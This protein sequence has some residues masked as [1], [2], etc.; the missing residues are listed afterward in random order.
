MFAQE[1]VEQHGRPPVIAVDTYMWYFETVSAAKNNYTLAFFNRLNIFKKLGIDLIMVFDG[2]LKI[3][4]QRWGDKTLPGSIAT[5]AVENASYS[6]TSMFGLNGEGSTHRGTTKQS[7][8]EIIKELCKISGLTIVQAPAEGEAEC[9][10]LVKDGVADFVFSGD[11]DVLVFG[12]RN[13]IKYPNKNT[14]VVSWKNDILNTDKPSKNT[15]QGAN[16]LSHSVSDLPSDQMLM[17]VD[18]K[19]LPSSSATDRYICVIRIPEN[20]IF[21]QK[22]SFVFFA[23]LK[24]GDYHNGQNAVGRNYAYEL[25]FPASRYATNFLNIYRETLGPF[26]KLDF[27]SKDSVLN[28]SQIVSIEFI[29]DKMRDELKNNTSKYFSKKFPQ[30]ECAQAFKNFPTDQVILEYLSPL[31][32]SRNHISREQIIGGKQNIYLQKI[33]DYSTEFFQWKQPSHFIN[34]IL[35][36]LLPM[37]K[38]SNK[39][40]MDIVKKVDNSRASAFLDKGSVICGKPS[41][42]NSANAFSGNQAL[43]KS[44]T[45]G[46]NSSAARKEG[47]TSNKSSINTKRPDYYRITVVPQDILQELN[48]TVNMSDNTKNATSI[49]SN[50]FDKYTSDSVPSGAAQDALETVVRFTVL[51]SV[52]KQM[53]FDYIGDFEIQQASK[54][55]KAKSLKSFGTLT[56]AV[57]YAKLTSSFGIARKKTTLDENVDYNKNNDNDSTDDELFPVSKSVA[58]TVCSFGN[59]FPGKDGISESPVTPRQLKTSNSLLTSQRSLKSGNVSL[60]R[61]R[62]LKPDTPS[63]ARTILLDPEPETPSANKNRSLKVGTRARLHR[64]SEIPQTSPVENELP[65]QYLPSSSDSLQIIE[66]E[67]FELNCL[68]SKATKENTLVVMNSLL[69]RQDFGSE[70]RSKQNHSRLFSNQNA[71]SSD[72]DSRKGGRTSSTL[73]HLASPFII[74]EEYVP[75]SAPAVQS[76][77]RITS[78]ASAGS[79]LDSTKIV[80]VSNN[81]SNDRLDNESIGLTSSVTSKRT[82]SL[83]SEPNN[84]GP[85]KAGRTG[86]SVRQTYLLDSFKSSKSTNSEP[87]VPHQEK[88][89]I[90]DA[91]DS[92]RINLKATVRGPGSY[93]NEVATHRNTIATISEARKLVNTSLEKDI[94]TF[95]DDETF[96]DFELSQK[97]K[98]EAKNGSGGW[99]GKGSSDV[100][101]TK[102][103]K[104]CTD[105]RSNAGIVFKNF[106]CSPTQNMPLVI[107]KQEEKTEAGLNE[108]VPLLDATA[109][110]PIPITQTDSLSNNNTASLDTDSPQPATENEKKR[111][112]ISRRVI[113]VETVV[114]TVITTYESEDPGGAP[115]IETSEPETK[116][117]TKVEEL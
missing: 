111:K 54:P 64:N 23:L 20:D 101:K 27:N 75:K 82:L 65:S 77:T 19:L 68:Q 7:D 115:I 40:L 46:E 37:V 33:W 87:A 99:K 18:T 34:T 113:T 58:P 116:S 11:S 21:L 114:K 69:E 10:R 9:V 102:I 31:V 106:T 32:N 97:D 43:S 93:T 95:S 112:V 72:T 22:D 90:S 104:E 63:V 61:Q 30:R 103:K 88:Q 85:C 4:K 16:R 25:S 12:A 39:K 66:K 83:V 110:G 71:V 51:S 96:S 15:S 91:G 117:S 28:S 38:D 17:S 56:K 47:S 80:E 107:I 5:G 109:G 59:I 78:T 55:K 42:F 44:D 79:N 2:E 105:N 89:D 35:P 57:K 52:L 50:D 73:D 62:P 36:T 8:L 84:K 45:F 49:T 29:K 67:T 3:H 1:Y 81:K 92:N 48:L 98:L 76:A 86:S 41:R 100:S 13:I 24:G 53:K 74:E 6:N 108:T 26:Y 94:L 14:M 60:P 70:C